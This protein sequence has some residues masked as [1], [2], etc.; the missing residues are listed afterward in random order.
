MLAP[1]VFRRNAAVQE[2]NFL[3]KG[4]RFRLDFCS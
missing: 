2:M 4:S 3:P 1:A